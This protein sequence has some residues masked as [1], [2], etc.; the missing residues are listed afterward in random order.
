MTVAPTKELV[1]FVEEAMADYAACVVRHAP[2]TDEQHIAFARAFGPLEL[3]PGYDKRKDT[4][5]RIAPELYFAGNIGPDNEIVPPKPRSQNISAASQRFHADSSFNALPSKWSMLRGVECP[6]SKIGGDTLFIDTRAAYDDLPEELKE[7]LEGLV[8]LHS[9]WRGREKAGLVVSDEMRARFDMPIARHPL[10][11]T[12]PNGRKY[13]YVGAH[14]TGVEGMDQEEG[15]A[16]VDDLYNRV[17]QMKYVHRHR[18]QV[19][20]I[21]IWE[22]RCAL[23]AATPLNTTEY[24]RDMRRATVNEAGPEV[25]A[26]FGSH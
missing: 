13:L 25:S 12:M 26:P 17:T 7:R 24:R 1:D 3:P 16:L 5:G 10:V 20:D 14:C 21:V 18:W 2:I 9:Y 4:P 23:L 19:G 6:P 11:R 8:G 15:E 22:N